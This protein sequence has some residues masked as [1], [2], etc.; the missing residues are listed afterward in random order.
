MTILDDIKAKV[1]KLYETNPDIHINIVVSYPKMCLV[2]EPAKITG[3]YKNLF[4]LEE[5]SKGSPHVHTFQYTDIY[6]KRIE[7]VEL[8]KG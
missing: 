5:Y 7:I 2:N 1:K 8:A 4:K 3:I 6:T